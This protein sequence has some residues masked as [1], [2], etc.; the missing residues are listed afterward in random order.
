[1]F[2]EETVATI[3]ENVATV[4]G[5]GKEVVDTSSKGKEFDLR[6]LGGQELSEEE[7][8]ELEEYENLVAISQDPCSLVKLMRKSWDASATVPDQK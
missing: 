5:K 4:P 6:H 1:M 3:E 2:A 8:N 7:K